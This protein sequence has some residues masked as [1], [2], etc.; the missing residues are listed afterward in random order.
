VYG[1]L[2]F[3]IQTFAQ[4]I[5]SFS[6]NVGTYQMKD[7]KEFQKVILNDYLSSSNVPIKATL[8]FP[9]SLQAEF[10]V[11]RDYDDSKLGVFLNYTATK[12]VLTYSDYSGSTSLEHRLKRVTPGIHFSTNVSKNLSLYGKLGISVT[13][14]SIVAETDLTGA[15]KIEEKNLFN[16]YAG[17]L[18]PGLQW[19]YP[20]ERFG[21]IVHLG[22]EFS[23][24]TK[25][26]ATET[27]GA[28][29][30]NNEGDPMF[31][32]WNGIR[33]GIGVTYKLHK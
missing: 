23:L 22:Y 16:A 5:I 4:D 17:I 11:Y 3:T 7:M 1:L 33:G 14:L 8:V 27:E 2:F 20:M 18:Q 9:A 19:D 10:G 28:Y 26:F 6:V 21:L 31:I 29:L 13:F 32:L 12:G 15:D 25:V 24:S 30:V